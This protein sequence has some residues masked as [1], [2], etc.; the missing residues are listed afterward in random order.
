MITLFLISIAIGSEFQSKSL[1]SS[2]FDS[3]IKVIGSEQYDKRDC[4]NDDEVL[5]QDDEGV[6]SCQYKDE[7]GNGGTI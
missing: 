6:W 1:P 5:T 2:L 4:L 7:S 3:S